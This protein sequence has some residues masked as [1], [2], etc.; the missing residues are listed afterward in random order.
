MVIWKYFI[1]CAFLNTLLSAGALAQDVQF[2]AEVDQNKVALGSSAQWTLTVTGTQDVPDPQ[3]PVV[4]GLDIRYLGP[5]TRISIVNG[6]YSSK[7]SWMYSVLPTR[8]GSFTIPSVQIHAGGQTYTTQPVTIDVVDEG[9]GIPSAV[10][11]GGGASASLTDKIFL[12]LRLPKEKVYVHER[13]P[14][15]ILLFIADV[16]VADV[17]FPEL[18][19]PGVDVEKF[20]QP[21]Q[22]EQVVNGVR[23]HIAEFN[24][25]I[26]PTRAG[27][28]TIGPATLECN[29]VTKPASG[30]P[31][32]AGGNSPLGGNV[33]DDDFFN[34]FFDRYEKRPMTLPS[35]TS[36]LTVLPLPEENRPAGFSGAVGE[37]GLDVTVGPAEVNVGDPITVKV[38]V[39]GDGNSRTVEPPV[40]TKEERFKVYDPLIKEED[41][42]KKS[43][44]VLIPESDQVTEVPALQ[45]SFFDPALQRYQTITK[46]PFPVAVQRPKGDQVSMVVPSPEGGAA[47]PA[48]GG[49]AGQDIVFIKESPGDFYT[50]GE[51]FYRTVP[52]YFAVIVFLGGWGM[53]YAF[54]RRTHKIATDVVYARRLRAPR[55]ARRGLQEA[56]RLQ[57]LEDAQKFY[58]ALFRTLQGYLGNKLHLSAGAL[59]L[60]TVKTRLSVRVDA[61]CLEEIRQAFEECDAIRYAPSRPDTRARA[62]SYAR[63]QRIIDAL[64]RSGS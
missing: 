63:I 46:G 34:S 18:K 52:F 12:V 48:A 64:E 56:R 35:K 36:A 5:A 17:R 37:F 32:L 31:E 51:R 6:R 23:Y 54:Y 11:P 20:S 59:T 1:L 53:L 15:K 40:F 33:F 47:T 39:S 7:K 3:I 61:K 24:T 9:N 8:V 44:Q 55:E 16:G 14:I 60:E 50:I 38:K 4:D 2:T 19:Q 21:Q 30:K 28:M 43:E 45:F 29:I 25:N 26:Y 42:S 57:G 49:A 22:Y 41:G 27:E 62:Q 13:L 58:D 10:S